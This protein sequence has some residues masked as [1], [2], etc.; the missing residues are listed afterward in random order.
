M[1]VLKEVRQHLRNYHLKSGIFHF[2]RGEFGPAAEFFTRALTENA[3]LTD[4]DRRN[5]EYY[6]VQT[7]IAA[8]AVSERE[9]DLAQAVEEYRA[10]LSVTPT[11]PDVHL[12][13]GDALWRLGQ[14]DDAVE[15]YRRAAFINPALDEAHLRLGFALLERRPAR[16]ESDTADLEAA[17]DA[18]R[19]AQRAREDNRRRHIEKAEDALLHGD[20]ETAREIYLDAFRQ[21][22]EEFRRRFQEGLRHLMDENW[23]DAAEELGEAARLF[24]RYADVHNYRGVALAEGGHYADAAAEFQRSIRINA[25]YLVAWLNLAFVAR[26]LGDFERAER[27]VHEVLRH[28]P[29]NTAALHLAEELRGAVRP[30]GRAGEGGAP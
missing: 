7:R 30:R 21:N 22:V 13:L 20:V 6:L 18:F 24:P 15:H 2:Y 17:R 28:E 12:K 26:S 23:A 5:A 29:D 27:A 9:E 11:Y 10:A 3:D 1:R 14:S 19:Q 4:A 16:A 25:G 8:A